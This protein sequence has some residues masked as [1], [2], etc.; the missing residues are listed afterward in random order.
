MPLA[1]AS[2]L[3]LAS[4]G[5]KAAVL[6]QLA[7]PNAAVGAPTSSTASTAQVC[8]IACIVTVRI[9][10]AVLCGLAARFPTPSFAR[11]L[12]ARA[13]GASCSCNG[14]SPILIEGSPESVK[15]S[16]NYRR[17]EEHTSE[18]QSLRHLVC[19]LLL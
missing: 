4:Q 9:G 7:W 6:R 14:N 13:R 18:L 17:S 1:A 15:L 11:A 12:L 3:K 19:R 10:P 2:F 5:S 16:M 8:R